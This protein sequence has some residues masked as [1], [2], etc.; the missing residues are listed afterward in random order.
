[1]G[2]PAHLAD[3]ERG[4]V[5]LDDTIRDVRLPVRLYANQNTHRLIPASLALAIV[6]GV[7][8]AV[9][10]RRNPAERSAA[11]EFMRELLRYTPRAAESDALAAR[12]LVEKS[13]LRELFWR[14]WLLQ[15]SEVHGRE[16]WEAARADGDKGFVIVFAHMVATWAVPAILGVRGFE[17]YIV[18]GP[19]YWAPLPPGYEGPAIKHRRIEY[20]VK[21][22][23]NRWLI[24]TDGRPERLPELIAAGQ[25]VAI[26]FDAP[27]RAATPFLGR[28]IAV[29]G[30]GAALAFHTG[31]KVLPVI[32]ER[33][34]TRIDLR[35]H[36][37]LDAT[38]YPDARSLRAAIAATF[39]PIVL[40]RPQEVEL[41]WF[42]SPLV[43]EAQPRP[44]RHAAAPEPAR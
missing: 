44:D 23:G 4:P 10:Q 36:A 22:L 35:F 32:P 8:P 18:V 37:P 29:G 30:G 38:D 39:E 5:P 15:K 25:P 27:G 16:H 20:G 28:M 43:T 1:M 33:H 7:G 17:H 2:V 42:P 34:G 9:R 13:K 12:W 24:S 40:A 41:A 11:E 21:P 14:P 31:A 3:E 26:A 19:H 6:A